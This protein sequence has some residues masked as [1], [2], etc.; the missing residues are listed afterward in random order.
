MVDVIAIAA[1][2]TS[3]RGARLKRIA[4]WSIRIAF[5][6]VAGTLAQAWGEKGTPCRTVR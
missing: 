4:R 6:I 3:A 2:R 1:T 5:M